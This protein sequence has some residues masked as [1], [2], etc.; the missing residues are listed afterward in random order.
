MELPFI[1]IQSA[2]NQSEFVSYMQCESFL[3]ME[4]FEKEAFKILLEQLL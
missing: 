4:R 1:A 3:V 2:D